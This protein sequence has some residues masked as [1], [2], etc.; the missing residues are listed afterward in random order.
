MKHWEI[1]NF[2]VNEI[3]YKEEINLNAFQ[4][5]NEKTKCEEYIYPK[6]INTLNQ[7]REILILICDYYYDGKD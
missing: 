5:I 2:Y 1:G 4:I 6:D 7:I 3:L